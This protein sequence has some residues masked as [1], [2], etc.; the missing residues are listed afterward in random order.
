LG[1]NRARGG[2]GDPLRTR[3]PFCSGEEAI[4]TRI[5]RFSMAVVSA[6]DARLSPA[7]G[8]ELATYVEGG[9]GLHLVKVQRDFDPA[10]LH[11]LRREV[12]LVNP[13]D[14]TRQFAASLAR[15]A[16]GFNVGRMQ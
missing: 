14:R 4:S 7:Q 8:E 2:A 15:Q 9:L 1:E 12:L 6:L 13:C 10:P 16:R 3:H 11:R 5:T